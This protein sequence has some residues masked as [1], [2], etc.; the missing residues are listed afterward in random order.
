MNKENSQH[1]RKII[2]KKI[3][4]PRAA[5]L[6]QMQPTDYITCIFLPSASIIWYIGFSWHSKFHPVSSRRWINNFHLFSPN[7]NYCGPMSTRSPGWNQHSSHK[8]SV[9]IS[10]TEEFGLTQAGQGH[11]LIPKKEAK[12]LPSH[13]FLPKQGS[14]H[15][16]NTRPG[17]VQGSMIMKPFHWSNRN[18][19]WLL[20]LIGKPKMQT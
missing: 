7:H 4:L 9:H 14:A 16:Y 10:G 19:T 12:I 13:F 8:E 11:K 1:N 20:M 15:S 18:Q 6:E 5:F 17:W 3:S 2:T